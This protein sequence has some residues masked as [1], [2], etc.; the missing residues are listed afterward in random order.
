MSV[1]P[2]P[3]SSGI[4]FNPA[5]YV[6]SDQRLLLGSTG[7]TGQ[8]GSAANT[9]A[10]GFT[11]PTG[12]TGP[13]GSDGSA[14]NTGATGY[15]GYTGVTGPTGA[16]GSAAN[17]GATGPTGYT[18][19]I[20]VTG[21]PGFAST[22]GATGVTGST[23]PTGSIGVTGATGSIG[24]AGSTGYTGATGVTGPTGAD[25]SAANTGAT[26]YT[27]YTGPT[28]IGSTGPTGLSLTGP[29][30]YTG[31]TGPTGI[32]STGPTGL[33]LTGPTGYTGYTGPTGVGLTGPTGV[34]GPFANYPIIDLNSSLT[35]SSTYENKTVVFTNNEFLTASISAYSGIPI[36]TVYEFINKNSPCTTFS[37]SDSSTLLNNGL[38][39][40]RYNKAVLRYI[41]AGTFDLTGTVNNY[42]IGQYQWNPAVLGSMKNTSN[43][44]LTT[45][46]YGTNVALSTIDESYSNKSGV[47]I[48]TSTSAGSRVAYNPNIKSLY[49]DGTDALIA[50]VGYGILGSSFYFVINNTTDSFTLFSQAKTGLGKILVEYVSGNIGLKLVSNDGSTFNSTTLPMAIGPNVVG[51]VIANG[52]SGTCYLGVN[53]S[54]VSLAFTNGL[55]SNNAQTCI[56]CDSNLTTGNYSLTNVFTGTMQLIQMSYN[57]NQSLLQ[58]T[59]TMNTLYTT[60]VMEALELLMGYTG[61]TGATGPTGPTG[62]GSTGPTGYTGLSIT[63]PTG[64]TGYTGPTGIGSTGPTGLSLTGPTGYTGLSITGPTGIGSTGPTGYTG[65]IGVT[66]P[67]GMTNYSNEIERGYSSTELTSECIGKFVM[68][69]GSTGPVTMNAS[70]FSSGDEFRLLN[71]S[72]PDGLWLSDAFIVP[73]GSYPPGHKLLYWG[74]MWVRYVSPNGFYCTGDIVDL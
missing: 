60:Y 20:G 33:S 41:S 3:Q 67:T 21:P 69:N 7:P 19:P 28:G 32:G 62:I 2:K 46:T 59:R 26:G 4:P 38:Q 5:N 24:Q 16:D 74:Q 45:E 53:N 65:P 37:V 66:G 8:P 36:G 1:Y 52:S 54:Y 29:T 39:L 48:I 10:T 55:T 6:L 31:Y 49:F 11:G 50:T 58:F 13:T 47:Y 12:K 73:P 57:T 51:L 22:T 44:V 14:A 34:T 64:S 27:G 61:P 71:G 25:G 30:G 56:G 40:T 35:L 23:G 68:W 42:I 18:G 17:T 72:Q 70:G 9:G 43:Q 15:T 63:G